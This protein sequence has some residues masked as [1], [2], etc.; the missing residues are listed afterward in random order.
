MAA[1]SAGRPCP[2]AL[3]AAAESPGS[4]TVAGSTGTS[5]ALSGGTLRARLH[6]L[7]RRPGLVCRHALR[8]GRP[9]RLRFRA[10]AFGAPQ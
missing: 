3:L 1:L 2:A 8:Q 10:S 7:E 4:D 5:S 6:Q 9:I